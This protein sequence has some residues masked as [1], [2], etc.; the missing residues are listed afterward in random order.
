LARLPR[1]DSERFPQRE[2]VWSLV[3]RVTQERNGFGSSIGFDQR[4][5]TS[6][7]E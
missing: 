6:S 2:V 5:A 1:S 7:F 4:A 3:D